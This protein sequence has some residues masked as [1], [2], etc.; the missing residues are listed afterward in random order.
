MKVVSKYRQ[1]ETSLL[2]SELSFPFW[3]VFFFLF[4]LASFISVHPEYILNLLIFFLIVHSCRF[5]PNVFNGC[6]GKE[7][8]VTELTG[9]KHCS[10][11]HKLQYWHN[12]VYQETKR[13][14]CLLSAAAENYTY[15]KMHVCLR[16]QWRQWQ[17]QILEKWMMT[18]ERKVPIRN[19]NNYAICTHLFFSQCHCKCCTEFLTT[20]F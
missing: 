18:K 1:Y 4:H 6:L 3:G 17:R 11:F 14:S 9:S 8:A 12:P 13:Y 5:H 20:F 2:H 7:I 15:L 19:E 16:K 10:V